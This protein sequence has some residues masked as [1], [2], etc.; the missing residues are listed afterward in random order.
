[1]YSGYGGESG[2]SLLGDNKNKIKI[3]Q[4]KTNSITLHDI[5][6]NYEKNKYVISIIKLDIEGYEKNLF[7]YEKKFLKK[8]PVIFVELHERIVKNCE[9]EFK[10]FVKNRFT[11]KMSG[12]KY[13][14]V[15][16]V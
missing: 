12:E 3:N 14:S 16:T 9:Y 4:K 10:K 13:I 11:K 5:K 2:F 15:G 1:L 6:N 8:I 7:K